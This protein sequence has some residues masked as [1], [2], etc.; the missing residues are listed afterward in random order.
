MCRQLGL[1]KASAEV[2]TWAY[3]LD[4]NQV[5]GFSHSPSSEAAVTPHLHLEEN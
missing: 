1:A 2:E 5:K 4:N 3:F